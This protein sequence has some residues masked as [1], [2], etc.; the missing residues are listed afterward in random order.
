MKTSLG[1][2]LVAIAACMLALLGAAPK[3]SKDSW[4]LVPIPDT[5]KVPPSGKLASSDGFAWYRCLVKIPASWK[6]RD[7]DLFVEPVDDARAV[8]FNGVQVGAAG[9][10]RCYTL[11]RF[12]SR[13]K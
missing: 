13:G 2:A 3:A 7:L 1:A 12:L 6:D 9:T 11:S 4:H 10:P 8:Y 5:W